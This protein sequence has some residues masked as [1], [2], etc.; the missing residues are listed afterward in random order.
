MKLKRIF[1]FLILLL[2]VQTGSSQGLENFKLNEVQIANTKGL[3]N[4]YGEHVP[5]IEIANTSWSS[6]DLRG[7]YITNDRSVLD[8]NLTAPERIAKMSLIPKGD[9]RTDIAPQGHIVLYADGK[10]N[11]GT[12][13]TN[14]VLQAGQN[15]F[16]ALYEGNGTKLIDSVSVPAS[17]PVDCSWAR[18]QK[19]GTKNV[20]WQICEA[21]KVSPN[22]DN[23]TNVGKKDM[24]AEWKEKDPHGF[25]MTILGMGI[26]LCGLLLLC[27]FFNIFGWAARKLSAR[28][29]G[30]QQATATAKK[31][32]GNKNTAPADETALAVATLAATRAFKENGTLADDDI[33]AVIALALYEELD[34]HDKESGVIT[35]KPTHSPWKQRGLEMA[36]RITK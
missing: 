16:I 27:I 36:K 10:S 7:C 28:K 32:H 20:V 5:W 22:A 35:I 3:T 25:A 34:A 17:L 13:H 6:T 12:L 33:L 30:E 24:V 19:E 14:F 2:T 26:V 8:K 11:L 9:A 18:F 29:G 31:A 21:D 1:G 4:E 23:G 15:N